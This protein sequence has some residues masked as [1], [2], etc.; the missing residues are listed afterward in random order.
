MPSPARVLRL[1]LAFAA[2]ALVAAACGN[3]SHNPPDPSPSASPSP[4]PQARTEA[5]FDSASAL[6]HVRELSAGIGIRAAGTDAERQAA[7]YIRGELASYGYDTSLQPFSFDAYEEVSASVDMTAP[8]ERS[9]PA[10]ALEFSR[11]G[12]VE[13]DLINAGRG[14]QVEFPA[15]TSG[16]MALVQRGDITFHE[17]VAN[18]AAAGATAVIVYNNLAGPFRGVMRQPGD[19][20]AVSIS[21]EDG[22]ALLGLLAAGPVTARVTVEGRTAQASSQNVI[23]EPPDG[24]CRVVAGGH[25]DSVPDGPGANDNASGTAVVIEMARVLASDGEFADVCFVLFGSEEI[26]LVG[27]SHYVASLSAAEVEGVEGMLNFDMLS[28]GDTWPLEGSDEMVAIASRE[29]ERLGLPHEKGDLPP[30][31]GSDHTPF[32]DAGIPAVIFNCFCDAHYHTA[33]DRIDFVE[34][35][36]LGEAGAMGL[37]IIDELLAD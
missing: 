3:D 19:I 37:G 14:R 10:Q 16:K 36:R 15:G 25:Y 1:L 34:Q 30:G 8:E 20:P 4:S 2:V 23:A 35:D 17:K 6:E 7:D 29:A 21:L 9:V 27:S 13:G 26:G 24:K 28:T 22:Q 18:A 32:I 11:S 31:A 5:S 12:T 33:D